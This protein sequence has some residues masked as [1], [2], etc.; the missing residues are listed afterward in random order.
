MG[1]WQSHLTSALALRGRAV[2]VTTEGITVSPAR[3]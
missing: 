2:R 1:N 3:P